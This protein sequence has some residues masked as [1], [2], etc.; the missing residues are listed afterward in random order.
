[1]LWLD[2]KFARPST[3]EMNRILERLGDGPRPAS[4]LVH[5]SEGALALRWLRAKGKVHFTKQGLVK[6]SIRE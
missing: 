1:M 2:P 6:R 4:E 5:C 3:R